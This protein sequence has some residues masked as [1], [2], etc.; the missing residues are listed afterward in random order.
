MSGDRRKSDSRRSSDRRAG[1]RRREDADRRIAD[2]RRNVDTTA[3]TTKRAAAAP[4]K[5]ESS[6]KPV[7]TAF[8]RLLKK[9]AIVFS[10]LLLIF[11]AVIVYFFSNLD[12]YMNRAAQKIEVELTKATLDP[13]SLTDRTTKAR[14]YLKVKNNLPM[15]VLLQ[16][17]RMDVKLSDYTIAKG[18]QIMPRETIKGGAESVVALQFHV[19]SIMTR[20]GLQKAVEKNSGPLLKSL[21]ARLQGKNNSI[22]DNLK[23]VMKIGGSAEFRMIIGGV[24]IPFTRIL[25]FNQG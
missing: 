3:K 20:R 11:T 19:D 16:N 15:A 18:V 12:Y 13:E 21:Y 1:D 7:I 4:Q 23:G 9:A 22:T 25:D 6:P 8:Q 10:I 17:L 14:V 2:G 24:E 5:T